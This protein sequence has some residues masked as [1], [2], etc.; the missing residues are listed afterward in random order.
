MKSYFKTMK[1]YFKTENVD[2]EW[3]MHLKAA[4]GEG[5][6]PIHVISLVPTEGGGWCHT[7]GHGAGGYWTFPN[8]ET[9]TL[10]C[11]LPPELIGE[12]L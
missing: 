5:L 4:V 9:V 8:D 2:H 1:S 6:C 10:S 12:M 11:P 7:C 3:F